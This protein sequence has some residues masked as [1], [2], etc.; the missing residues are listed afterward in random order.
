MPDIN[1]Q[2]K[3]INEIESRFEFADGKIV[4]HRDHFDLWKWSRQALGL[5]GGLLGWAAFFQEK[6]RLQASRNLQKFS[7]H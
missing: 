3:V 1:R 2:R 4:R 6:V 5:R 7:A